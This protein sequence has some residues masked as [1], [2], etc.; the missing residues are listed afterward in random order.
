MRKITFKEKNFWMLVA[1]SSVVMEIITVLCRIMIGNSAEELNATQNPPF[2][3]KIH[4]M[5][6]AL[7]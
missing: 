2:L 5:F 4:H 6:W 3:L 7:P 1:G